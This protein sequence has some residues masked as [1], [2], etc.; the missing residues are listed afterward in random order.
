[1]SPSRR[2]LIKF[3]TAGA[4]L[5]S[6]PA[7]NVPAAMAHLTE[8]IHADAVLKPGS[9]AVDTSTALGSQQDVWY[10]SIAPE[11]WASYAKAQARLE[12][13]VPEIDGRRTDPVI[14]RAYND[15]TASMLALINASHRAGLRQGAKFEHL[16]LSLVDDHAQCRSCWGTGARGN[17]VCGTCNGSGIVAFVDGLER[18]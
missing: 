8:P 7:T 12:A 4:F 2:D 11:E 1:M 3:A 15:F 13:V 6:L 10:T 18:H 16:R 17:Q 9:F 14:W 5:T